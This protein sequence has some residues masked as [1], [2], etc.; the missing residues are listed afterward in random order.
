MYI[1]IHTCDAHTHY[2]SCDRGLVGGQQLV[3]QVLLKSPTKET[4]FYERDL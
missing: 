1:Y 3:K 2:P 4:I